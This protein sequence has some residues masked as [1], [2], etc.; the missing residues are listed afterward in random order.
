MEELTVD[1][2]ICAGDIIGYYCWP[3]EIIDLL[4]SHNVDVV[5]GNHDAIAVLEEQFN[6]EIRYFNDIAK[7]SLKW[8]R[9]R[10]KTSQTHW[11]YVQ[12]L[13]LTKTITYDN[14]KIFLCQCPQPDYT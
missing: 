14:C 12:N 8:T 4:Q 7:R 10:L 6:E 11:D 1:Q 2:I 9:N 3:L 5:L 13:P